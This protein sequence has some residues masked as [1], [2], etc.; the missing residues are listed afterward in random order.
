MKH[1]QLDNQPFDADSERGVY[2]LLKS[3]TN[4]QKSQI[5]ITKSRP[6]SWNHEITSEII[7][8]QMK[9]W[10]HKG[11]HEITNQIMKSQIKSWNHESNHEITNEIMKSQEKSWNQ[12][13]KSRNHE[14]KI[15]RIRNQ[16]VLIIDFST[17]MP[18]LNSSSNYFNWDLHLYIRLISKGSDVHPEIE[19]S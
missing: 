3:C 8:S 6:K 18:S 4:C 11:N 5:K 15:T 2:H 13:I 10:N 7:E 16:D 19:T 12:N 17:F 14:I 9:S 1:N